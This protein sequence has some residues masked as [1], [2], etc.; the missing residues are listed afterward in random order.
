MSVLFD[1]MKISIGISRTLFDFDSL[2]FWLSQRQ[3][4]WF[5]LS[6]HGKDQ[7]LQY[8][9]CTLLKFCSLKFRVL[10]QVKAQINYPWKLPP[11]VAAYAVSVLLSLRRRIVASRMV[12]MPAAGPITNLLRGI[13]SPVRLIEVR[14]SLN[15]LSEFLSYH[16]ATLRSVVDENAV[17]FPRE[18]TNRCY[19]NW[20]ETVIGV[21]NNSLISE[22]KGL[23]LI[24]RT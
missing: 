5:M 21:L 2:V 13:T 12:F 3:E 10:D 18:G 1:K 15:Q 23:L 20:I 22:T 17:R 16:V 24:V 19:F 9:T 6:N 7:A 8:S 14:F 11:I 4:I